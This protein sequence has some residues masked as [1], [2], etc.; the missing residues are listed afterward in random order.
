MGYWG[1]IR[2]NLDKLQRSIQQVKKGWEQLYDLLFHLGVKL[3]RL[4]DQMQADQPLLLKLAEGQLGIENHFKTFAREFQAN[5]FQESFKWL[6]THMDN[7]L[8]QLYRSF[9]EEQQEMVRD[10]Q[11][12][13]TGCHTGTLCHHRVQGD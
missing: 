13:G 9:I 3:Y 2:D 7:L 11:E 8:N 1:N 5:L 4:S 12:L 10:R 6:I